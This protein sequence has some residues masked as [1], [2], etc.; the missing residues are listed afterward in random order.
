MAENTKIKAILK[1]FI[2]PDFTNLTDYIYNYSVTVDA[3]LTPIQ[4][5]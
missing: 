2:S 4:Y 1:V 5:L 3:I